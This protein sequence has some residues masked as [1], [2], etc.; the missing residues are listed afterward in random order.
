MTEVIDIFRDSYERCTAVA[1]FMD[2]FYERFMYSS[3]EVA[4]KFQ[5]TEFRKQKAIVLHS[6]QMLS[7]SF[8][9]DA[10]AEEYLHSLAQRHA[11][12]ALD[13]RPDLYE[14]WLDSL[15]STV[16]ETDPEFSNEIENAWETVMKHGIEIMIAA[17]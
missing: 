1:S 3:D 15:L 5:N 12:G 17:Y 9:G 10:Q 7:L 2:R 13:I 8:H 16:E 6:L 14:L 11:R 4:Q